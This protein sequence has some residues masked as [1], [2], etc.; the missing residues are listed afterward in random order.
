M[1]TVDPGGPRL[2]YTGQTDTAVNA[3]YIDMPTGSGVVLV[4]KISGKQSE[5]VLL[6]SGS[7]G[8]V[9]VP[10]RRSTPAGEYY[11][12]AADE[13]GNEIAQ[14]VAFYINNQGGP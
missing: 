10:I 2:N 3:D 1:N 8:S 5:S 14:T 9:S 7:S 4:N 6:V 12:A 11:L 13:S